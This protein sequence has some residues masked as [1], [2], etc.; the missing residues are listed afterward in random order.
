MPSSTVRTTQW[1]PVGT[2]A[3]SMISFANAFEPSSR[4]ASRMGPKHRDAR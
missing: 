2:P 4:A 3:A 1:P